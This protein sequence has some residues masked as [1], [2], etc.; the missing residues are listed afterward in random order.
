ME[1]N[2]E[3]KSG[4]NCV[5]LCVKALLEVCEPGSKHLEIAVVRK[6]VDG[7][8]TLDEKIV[9]EVIKKIEDEKAAAEEAKKRRAQAA[10]E[11]ARAAQ[12]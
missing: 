1:K 3:E 7:V 4:D 5:E 2:Y 10:E 6:G 11:A 8:D 9:D 12:G